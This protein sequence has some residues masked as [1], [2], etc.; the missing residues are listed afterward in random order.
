MSVRRTAS[1]RSFLVIPPSNCHNIHSTFVF[2]LGC[3]RTTA[4][5]SSKFVGN[6]NTWWTWVLLAVLDRTS[7]P[8]TSTFGKHG[9]GYLRFSYANSLANIKETLKRIKKFL[10]VGQTLRQ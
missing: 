10:S 3:G 9:D 7:E 4:L 2:C 8:S 5:N 6:F 1:Y